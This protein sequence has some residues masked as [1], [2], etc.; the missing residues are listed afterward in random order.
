MRASLSRPI[1]VLLAPV[2]AALLLLP[3]A[4]PA[5]AA[6]HPGSDPSSFTAIGSQVFFA[7]TTAAHGRELWVTDG[8][9]A[10]TH[11]VADIN[12]TVFGSG[13]AQLTALGNKVFFVVDD[14]AGPALWKSDGTASGT[15]QLFPG[16]GYDINGL[17]NVGG[18]LFFTGERKLLVSDGTVR[19]TR[20]IADVGYAEGISA[21]LGG[22][23]YFFASLSWPDDDFSWSL[24]RSDGTSAGTSVVAQVES[25]D[26]LRNYWPLEVVASGNRLYFE[27]YEPRAAGRGEEVAF[28]DLWQSD[29]TAAGTRQVRD[30]D[31]ESVPDWI[32]TDLADLNGTLYFGA[33]DKVGLA[34]WKSDGTDA[35]TRIVKRISPDVM[36][37]VG[38]RLLFFADDGTGM[39]LWR[40]RGTARTT[41]EV[42]P[43][44][45]PPGCIGWYSQ[46]T[47]CHLDE[48]PAAIGSRLF[49]PASSVGNGTELWVSDGTSVGT[50]QVKNILYGGA[51]S[52]P[53]DLTAVG[54]LLYFSARDANHGRELW[55][56]DGTT[57][58][59]HMVLD[60]N[61]G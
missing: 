41:V 31:P 38:S 47:Y 49:F 37:A 26:G 50:H 5:N 52:N 36:T 8:T 54:S 30:F 22:V 53:S 39:A 12:P 45:L 6:T 40:T 34:L 48:T 17:T 10:G 58:G 46:D 21:D 29:G 33:E 60:I 57:R 2:I 61:P 15:K 4:V 19:G 43:I 32:P 11:E 25:P 9:A 7:A 55:V 42:Y 28:A 20:A 3:S 1:L 44:A 13:P 23:Y 35:G 18:R 16:K 14:G 24:W 27:M 51:S 59:T 56:S